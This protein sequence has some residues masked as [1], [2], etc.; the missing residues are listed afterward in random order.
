MSKFIKFADALLQNGFFTTDITTASESPAVRSLSEKSLDESFTEEQL[1]VSALLRMGSSSKLKEE[2]SEN[3]FGNSHFRNSPEFETISTY[4]RC[5][6]SLLQHCVD[7][8]DLGV[9]KKLEL[10]SL[11]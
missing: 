8:L 11:F 1:A 10:N 4:R 7:R 2:L 9:K 6:V 3:L 5:A